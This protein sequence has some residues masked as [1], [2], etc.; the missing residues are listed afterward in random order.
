M[1][2]LESTKTLVILILFTVVIDMLQQI[3]KHFD[4]NGHL[5]HLILLDQPCLVL[6]GALLPVRADASGPREQREEAGGVHGVRLLPGGGG[7][8]GRASHSGAV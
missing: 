2:L 8:R 1:M 4:A 6:Q 3:R 5:K 7:A